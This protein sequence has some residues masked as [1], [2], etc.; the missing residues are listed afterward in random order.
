MSTIKEVSLEAIKKLPEDCSASDIM[1][2]L[3][4]ISQVMEGLNDAQEGRMITTNE[5]LLQVER[6]GK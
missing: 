1:Y 4:V 2:E 3:H 5:L 6:W